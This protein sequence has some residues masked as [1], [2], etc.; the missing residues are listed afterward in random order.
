MRRRVFMAIL[1]V[2]MKRAFVA[3]VLLA[4]FAALLA[5]RARPHPYAYG[6]FQILRQEV[7]FS[8]V[9]KHVVLSGG[10][11]VTA[12]SLDHHRMAGR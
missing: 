9:P 5:V 1:D 4:G 3:V 10:T 7:D 8:G 12:A 6:T 11:E 2:S